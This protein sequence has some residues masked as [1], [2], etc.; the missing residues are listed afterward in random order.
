MPAADR[1]R[2][3]VH[4]LHLHAGRLAPSD[5]AVA[6]RWLLSAGAVA[7]L[8]EASLLPHP[9]VLEAFVRVLG[10]DADHF[11]QLLDHARR[12]ATGGAAY[13]QPA[14]FQNTSPTTDPAADSTGP[15]DP[16]PTDAQPHPV[17]PDA[18]M[19]TFSKVFLEERTVEDGR[20]RLLHKL[21]GQQAPARVTNSTQ[22]RPLAAIVEA[23]RHPH[24]HLAAE[25][26]LVAARASA[27]APQKATAVP[28]TQADG[29]EWPMNLALAQPAT[30]LPTG[31]S[32][33]TESTQHAPG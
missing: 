19:K 26:L 1:L 13:L 15:S 2:T 25:G 12:E 5:V 3:A 14:L 8:L 6:S 33:P 30:Q 18:V 24:P 11:K 16:P 28:K 27:G 29:A 32:G 10:G 17:G 23:L 20:A 9:H 7:S 4:T 31:P 21:A 22:P